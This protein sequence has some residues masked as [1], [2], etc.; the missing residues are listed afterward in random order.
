MCWHKWSKYDDPKVV[1]NSEG[2]PEVAQKA[3]CKKCNA[4][5]YRRVLIQND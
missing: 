5:R 4:V 2:G 3:V 1:T